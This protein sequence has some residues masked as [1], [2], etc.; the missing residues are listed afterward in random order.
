[1][2]KLEQT[3]SF[4]L[5]TQVDTKNIKTHILLHIF[6][7]LKVAYIINGYKEVWMV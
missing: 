7:C 4:A 1:M 5:P 3:N 6:L 2:R